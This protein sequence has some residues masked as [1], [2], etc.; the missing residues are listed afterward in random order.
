[1]II[2]CC[3]ALQSKSADAYNEICYDQKN[4]T[5]FVVM[6]S[7][8]RLQNYKNYIHPKQGFNH[9]IINELKNKIKNFSD[10]EHFM[11]MLFN[12]IKTQENLVFS[13][14]KNTGYLIILVDHSDVNLNY[15]I[16][17]ETNATAFYVPVF[18]LQIESTL[19]NLV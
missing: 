13:V 3:L 11:M 17:Q 1:M 18:L 16:L 9:E 14:S 6:E 5:G 2:W 12:E 19:P 7:Q 10:I 4:G 8:R 15:A